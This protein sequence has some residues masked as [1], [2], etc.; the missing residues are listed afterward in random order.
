MTWATF[1]SALCLQ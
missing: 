1:T